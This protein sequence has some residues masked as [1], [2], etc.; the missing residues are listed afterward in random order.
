MMVE[1]QTKTRVWDDSSLFPE[2]STNNGVQEFHLRRDKFL[3]ARRDSLFLFEVLPVI[4]W[5][6]I[7]RLKSAWSM[8]RL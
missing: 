7:L 4:Y 1:N 5:T 2:N 3:E 6:F 8:N